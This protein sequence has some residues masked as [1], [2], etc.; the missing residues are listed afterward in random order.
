M[1]RRIVEQIEIEASPARIFE[2]LTDPAQLLA[3]WG[4]RSSYPSMHW[5]LDPRVGGKWLSRWRGPDGAEFGLGG[6]ILALDPPRLLAYSWWDERYPGLPLTTVRYELTTT[7]TGTLVTMTHDGFDDVR[8]DFDDYN[9]GWSTVMRKLREHAESGGPFRANRD[10]AIEV[11]SLVDAKA[12]YAGTLGFSIRSFDDEHLE[13]DA[14]SF[15]LWVNRAASRAGRRSFIPSLDVPDVVKA[16]VALESAGCRV[17]RG[18]DRG[19]Y[20]VDPFGFT[21]DVVERRD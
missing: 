20:I 5:E 2:A 11:E 14:G 16:R 18:G 17:V 4:D 10:I 9:G 3:W 1:A 7:P 19:F 6:E 8:A 21:I 15:R 12:F 13:L